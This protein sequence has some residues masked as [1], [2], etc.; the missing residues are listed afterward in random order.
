MVAVSP[1]FA[2]VV[3]ASIAM[4]EVCSFAVVAM[5]V[6]V[7]TIDELLMIDF[8]ASTSVSALGKEARRLGLSSVLFATVAESCAVASLA[9]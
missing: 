8:F 9:V 2:V 5:V 6:L 1:I 4:V 7:A 3:D